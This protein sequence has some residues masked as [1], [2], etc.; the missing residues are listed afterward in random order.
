MMNNYVQPVTVGRQQFDGL[1]RPLS[2]QCGGRTTEYRY[3]PGQLQPTHNILAD[4]K[5]VDFRYLKALENLVEQILPA[6]ESAHG[7]SYDRTL[8]TT[9]S[10]SG[11]LGVQ[12]MTFTAAGKPQTDT[13]TVDG[14]KH[15]TTWRYS[16]G[17]LQLGFEDA[18][19]VDHQRAFDSAGRLQRITVASVTSEIG[20][21]AFS[22]PH[23]YTTR[24]TVSGTRLTQTLTYDSLGREQTRTYDAVVEGQSSRKV[25]TLTYTDLDQLKSRRWD[26]GSVQ[27]EERFTYD[28]HGRLNT[29]EADAAVAPKDPFGNR[30]VKQVF[31]LDALDCYIDVVS[32]FADNSSDTAT[33]EYENRSDPTQVTRIA[34]THASWPRQIDLAYDA[35]GRLE[36]DSLGRVLTWDGQDRL[37]SVSYQGQTCTYGYDPAGNLCDRRVDGQLSRS[38]H[39]ANNLTHELRGEEQLRLIGDAGQLFAVDRLAAG[40]RRA[41]LLG[42]D[43]QGSVRLEAD[44]ALRQYHYTAHGADG[45]S[46]QSAASPFGFAGERR[47][48][49]TGWYIAAGYR[50]YDP[51]LMTFLAP[52]SAS[53]FGR[54]GLNP[55][56]Y[57]GGDPVNRFDPDGHSWF[58]WVALGFAVAAMVIALAPLAPALT[59]AVVAGATASAAGI[60]VG[61]TVAAA[62]L[63]FGMTASSTVGV[64]GT[65]AAV[66]SVVKLGTQIA[67]LAITAKNPDSEAAKILGY[68]E[69]GVGLIGTGASFGSAAPKAFEAFKSYKG[70]YQTLHNAETWLKPLGGPASAVTSTLTSVEKWVA[71]PAKEPAQEDPVQTAQQGPVAATNSQSR[72]IGPRVEQS[73]QANRASLPASQRAE[74]GPSQRVSEIISRSGAPSLFE[75]RRNAGA[76][77]NPPVSRQFN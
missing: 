51:V 55:Y 42:C 4:G 56:G 43:A 26:D 6:G 68:V 63:A 58:K 59:A 9:A 39:S 14:Q 73:A 46:S 2:I 65:I 16:L 62:G 50:P 34:H 75:R 12:Q 53:P 17:G 5:R 38:F 31:R 41:T 36:R 49:L 64:L 23:T 28:R 48:P 3:T 76:G 33:F 69:F 13:W 18:A 54:G 52:D 57:C 67:G 45:G 72:Q 8:G 61:G 19:G 21:D 24:D 60:G 25:Q 15:V 29:Y 7:F 47:E 66:A 37:Q 44:E 32:T 27:G 74:T 77:D 1:G 30:V 22:R 70:A 40:V 10:A 11:P 71:S 20:Y 35:R